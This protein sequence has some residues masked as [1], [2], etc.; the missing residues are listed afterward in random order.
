MSLT[1]SQAHA[2]REL[3]GTAEAHGFIPQR[4]LDELLARELIY[5]RNP[6]EVDFTPR[7]KQVYDELTASAGNEVGPPSHAGQ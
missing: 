2:M 7:G 3:G 4:I 1:E 6:G 5:W